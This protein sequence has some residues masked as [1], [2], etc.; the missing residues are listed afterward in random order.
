MP[1]TEKHH[2][3]ERAQSRCGQDLFQRPRL[4]VVTGSCYLGGFI[5]DDP[6][7]QA[8]IQKKTS[9]WVAAIHELSLVVEKYLQIAYA[10]LQKSLQQEWQFIQQVTKDLN[11]E[12]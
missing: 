9:S 4:T 10:G 8:W 11:G 1:T 6:N 3:C 2:H 5:G 7:Q 12:F